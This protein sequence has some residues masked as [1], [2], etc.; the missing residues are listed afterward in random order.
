MG[1]LHATAFLGCGSCLEGSSLE[2]RTSLSDFPSPVVIIV[3]MVTPLKV[4]NYISINCL[5][6]DRFKV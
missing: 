3:G 2:L 1:H 5:V 6:L 4:N